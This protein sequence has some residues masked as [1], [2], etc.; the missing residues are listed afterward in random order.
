MCYNFCR[1]LSSEWFDGLASIYLGFYYQNK[2][3]KVCI[4]DC[5]VKE[6]NCV[7]SKTGVI[8]IYLIK[9]KETTQGAFRTFNHKKKTEGTIVATLFICSENQLEDG[10]TQVAVRMHSL[11]RFSARSMWATDNNACL[12][13]GV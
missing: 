13:N 6:K 1:W 10:R 9:G 3:C 8:G 12:E 4:L 7:E 5:R 2:S 11:F